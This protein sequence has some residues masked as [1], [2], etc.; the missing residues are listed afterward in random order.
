MFKCIGILHI[1]SYF[2]LMFYCSSYI[3]IIVVLSFPDCIEVLVAF[4]IFS[5]G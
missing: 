4:H 5:F 3:Y 2:S 1:L